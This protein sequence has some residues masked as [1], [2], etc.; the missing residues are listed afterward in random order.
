MANEGKLVAFVVA[1]EAERG[2]SKMRDHVFGSNAAIIGDVVE[3]HKGQVVMRTS[4]GSSR[5][6]DMSVGDILPRIC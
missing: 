3:D 1:S 5:I 6:V 2:L 4:L